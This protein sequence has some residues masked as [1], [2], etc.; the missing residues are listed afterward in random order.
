MKS[1]EG[2]PLRDAYPGMASILTECILP[3]LPLLAGGASAAEIL[4]GF[5]YLDAEDINA[6]LAFAATEMDHSILRA[7]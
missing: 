7:A 3:Q 5:P 6:C 1:P 4:E 2:G